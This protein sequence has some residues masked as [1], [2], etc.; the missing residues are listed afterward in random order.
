MS[1]KSIKDCQD[2][3]AAYLFLQSPVDPSETPD[4]S[5]SAKSSCFVH[6]RNQVNVDSDDAFYHINIMVLYLCNKLC[7]DIPTLL[8]HF[9]FVITVNTRTQ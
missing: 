6:L 4:G 2:D 7:V 5:A 1:S 8:V 3:I 9:R